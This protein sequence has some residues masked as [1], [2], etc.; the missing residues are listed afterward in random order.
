MAHGLRHATEI[1]THI[2]AR[3][4]A[5]RLT[6]I[7]DS[8]RNMMT[9]IKIFK[10]TVITI[11]PMIANGF[12]KAI[13]MNAKKA[14]MDCK[15]KKGIKLC[16]L[17]RKFGIDK[18]HSLFKDVFA[19]FGGN[20]RQIVCGGAMLNP[21]V[22]KGFNDLGVHIS[23][24]YGITECGPLVSMNADTLK[25]AY[26]IGKPAP[27][28]EIR[29]DNVDENGVG[30]LCVRGASVSKGY[31]KDEEATK[32]VFYDD[33]FFNTGDLVRQDDKGRLFLMG[34]K[35]NVI[36][37]ENGKNICPEEIETEIQNT[38]EYGLE[39]V[40]YMAEFENKN[41]VKQNGIC[42]GLYIE[43]ENLRKNHEQILNDFRDLNK[44]LPTHKRIAYINLVDALWKNINKEN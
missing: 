30:E 32:Q 1:N 39:S 35:K 9:N 14:G 31:Y 15:L 36:V 29:L 40:I 18:T 21:E 7:N 4:C 42:V 22:V 13:W 12:Y 5:G 17:L 26:S 41:G 3:V 33:G 2:M 28:I 23:N 25:E 8:M 43:D 38:I 6:Y 19:P 37:L 44:V 10:P 27:N 34:R 11:V 16:N 24:G 20:L